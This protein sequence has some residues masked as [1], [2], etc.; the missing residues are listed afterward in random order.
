MTRDRDRRMR[1]PTRRHHRPN[2]VLRVQL[3]FASGLPL[4]PAL[5]TYAAIRAPSTVLI[6]RK[7]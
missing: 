2:G 4:P 6:T 7:I 1:D 5:P 3:T